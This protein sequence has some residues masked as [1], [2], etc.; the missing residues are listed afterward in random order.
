MDI[1]A[2]SLAPKWPPYWPTASGKDAISILQMKEMKKFAQLHTAGQ[3]LRN[4]QIHLW[5]W[6]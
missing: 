3:W 6:R 2:V 5:Y 4:K 1:H